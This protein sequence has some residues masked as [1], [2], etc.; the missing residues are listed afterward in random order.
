MVLVGDSAIEHWNGLSVGRPVKKLNGIKR[1]FEE[2]FTEKGGGKI[3]AVA[4]G[5]SGDRVSLMLQDPSAMHLTS[6]GCF[7]L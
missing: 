7:E 4:L 1:I 6:R 5:V 2:V 3:N